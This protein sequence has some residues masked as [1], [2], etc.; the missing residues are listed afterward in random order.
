MGAIGGRRAQGHRLEIVVAV[1]VGTH[2][3]GAEV[4]VVR[5][6]HACVREVVAL[7][8]WIGRDG[9][10]WSIRNAVIAAPHPLRV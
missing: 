3:L 2:S 10:H 1:A 4:R 7:C 8:M 5:M 6:G 9:R